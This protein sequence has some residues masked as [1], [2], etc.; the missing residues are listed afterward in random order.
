MLLVHAPT[1]N[2]EAQASILAPYQKNTSHYIQVWNI[3]NLYDRVLAD[4]S[5]GYLPTL[6]LWGKE[7]RV[8]N[9]A[10]A[11]KLAAK[12]PHHH[13]E[14]LSE[15]GHLPMIDAPDAVSHAYIR[16]LKDKSITA[17]SGH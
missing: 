8:F 2:L 10:S 6:I 1:L 5:G 7:D 4:H 15:V 14:D 3:V 13:R 16:F 17:P 12:Y 11:D 9:I